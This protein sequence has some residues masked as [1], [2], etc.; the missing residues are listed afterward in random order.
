MTFKRCSK[1]QQAWQTREEFLEDP[2]VV[3]VGYQT[4][5]GEL[6]LGFLLFNHDCRTT[7]ALEAG[8]FTDLYDGPVYTERRTGCEECP[9]YCLYQSE[10]RSCPAA[11]ECAYVR[12]V[13]QIVMKWQKRD[14]SSAAH[15]KA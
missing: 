13:L 9:G 1:C 8:I 4:N 15:K 5:F 10:L 2:A 7:I 12:E 11:C 3:L 14:G 6:Q